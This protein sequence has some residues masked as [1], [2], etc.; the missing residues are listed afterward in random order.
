MATYQPTDQIKVR[1]RL[2]PLVRRVKVKQVGFYANDASGN[3]VDW[4]VQTNV[5][6]EP[7]VGYVYEQARTVPAGNYIAK[8]A[9]QKLDDA[10]RQSARVLSF[11]V[12]DSM[13]AAIADAYRTLL[14]RAPHAG[15]V[16]AYLASGKGL[17]QI[18][19]EM[20]EFVRIA[21][22]NALA[23][24]WIP[25]ITFLPDAAFFGFPGV[26][27]TPRW[28]LRK[29]GPTALRVLI[30]T[31]TGPGTTSWAEVGLDTA[32]SSIR[33]YLVEF[34]RDALPLFRVGMTA[35]TGAAFLGPAGK[36]TTPRMMAR[37]S[38]GVITAVVKLVGGGWVPVGQ[39][40][41][42]SSEVNYLIETANWKVSGPR[43]ASE[44]ASF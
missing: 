41:V 24:S 27:V 10:W 31:M 12:Q 33:Y 26:A 39:D 14:G 25:P 38:G 30:G 13:Y 4:P 19:S 9:V 29:I 23:D 40:E 11:T 16:E 20:R 36:A 8:A 15:E 5:W 42:L 34:N 1:F 18:E 2:A 35:T 22:Q 44:T 37:V 21:K 43:G 6:I 3:P 17:A 7:G 32:L 28:I